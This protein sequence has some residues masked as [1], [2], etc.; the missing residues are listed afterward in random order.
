MCDT[1]ALFLQVLR[2]SQIVLKLLGDAL[3]TGVVDV[4]RV[5]E[6]RQMLQ[7]AAGRLHSGS[8]RLQDGCKNCRNCCKTYINRVRTLRHAFKT[9][10]AGVVQAKSLKP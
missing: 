4:G 1:E 6:L 3:Q 8:K 10:C 9:L 2:F 5:S 7:G